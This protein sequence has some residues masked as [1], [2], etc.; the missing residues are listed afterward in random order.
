VAG[1]LR[2]AAVGFGS[3]CLVG[4][5]FGREVGSAVFSGGGLAHRAADG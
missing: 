3:S 2:L 1:L 5:W 4:V